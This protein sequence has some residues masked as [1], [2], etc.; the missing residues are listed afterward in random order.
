M[1]RKLEVKEEA[2]RIYLRYSS[3]G[4][5]NHEGDEPG[6][7]MRFTAVGENENLQRASSASTF[8]SP[9]IDLATTPKRV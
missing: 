7:L 8:A 6:M 4:G 2:K 1:G 9:D 3:G 5:N